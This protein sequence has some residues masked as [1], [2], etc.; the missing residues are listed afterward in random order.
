MPQ[1][2]SED[3]GKLNLAKLSIKIGLLIK[4]KKP[5]NNNNNMTFKINY[6]TLTW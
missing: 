2:V 1:F 5:I 6:N 3:V 4:K